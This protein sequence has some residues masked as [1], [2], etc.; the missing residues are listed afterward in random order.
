MPLTKEK[1]ESKSQGAD[2][3]AAQSPT[4]TP[5]PQNTAEPVEA[6]LTGIPKSCKVLESGGTDGQFCFECKPR[7]LEVRHCFASKGVNDLAAACSHDGEDVACKDNDGKDLKFSI[8]PNQVEKALDSL[9]FIT[10]GA[11][12][13]AA[14]KLK[15]RPKEL[16]MLNGALAIVDKNALAIF[17]GEK[18]SE[19]ATEV[20]DEIRKHAPNLTAKQNEGIHSAVVKALTE[21][22]VTL[23]N[24]KV[25]L[26]QVAK[27]AVD[28]LNALPFDSIGGGSTKLDLVKL[29]EAFAAGKNPLEA[30]AGLVKTMNLGSLDE[31]LK[32]M[33]PAVQP[34]Q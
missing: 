1:V 27:S 15:D 21:L 4:P 30:L 22:G 31:I 29:R 3:E 17:R 32:K 6:N 19:I 11:R 23:K 24:N 34:K 25:D 33:Q 2:A 13:M 5:T 7:L 9:P 10:L 28:I 8:K 18:S 12:A 16:A 14:D 26:S 20:V